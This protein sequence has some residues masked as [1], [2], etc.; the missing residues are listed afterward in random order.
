[1]ASDAL[2]VS[3]SCSAF[4]SK[5]K[6]TGSRSSRRWRKQRR[7]LGPFGKAEARPEAA[8]HLCLPG[9]KGVPGVLGCQWEKQASPGQTAWPATLS[10][11]KLPLRSLLASSRWLWPSGWT[12]DAPFPAESPADPGAAGGELTPR[13]QP[14]SCLEAPGRAPGR[15]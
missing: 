15:E 3:M 14:S 2:L 6:L 4:V 12:A 11:D 5:G 1:M 9:A 10:W 7:D 13:P 8:I